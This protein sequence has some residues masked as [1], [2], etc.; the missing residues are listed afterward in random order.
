MTKTAS[1][2]RKRAEREALKA[3][4]SN[5][6][7][8]NSHNA[9]SADGSNTSDPN[10]ASDGG[11]AATKNGP[12]LPKM[13][14]EK[15]LFVENST[16]KD[17]VREAKLYDLL[18]SEN[19]SDR[20]EAAAAIISSLLDGEGVPEAV[21]QRHLDWRLFRGLAS[22]RAASRLG[23]SVVLTEILSQL[24]G[25]PKN[26]SRD[27]YPGLTFENVLGML[28]ERTHVG[29]N[30]PGQ[31]ER[32]L[33]FGQLFGLE[34]FVRARI[35]FIP[36][37]GPERWNEVLRLL[38]KLGN[39]KVW[40]RPQCGWVVAQALAQLDRNRVEMVLQQLVELGWAKTPEGVGIWLVAFE[41]CPDL[42]SGDHAKHH[43]PLASRN[44]GEL[45]G[46]LKES[47]QDDVEKQQQQQ[48]QQHQRRGGFSK[49]KQANWTP[50]LHFVWDLIVRHFLRRGPE[51]VDEFRA[52]WKR[53][54]DD[55][56]FAK[57]ATE[58]QKFRG[59]LV[60]Q[61]MLQ[62]YADIDDLLDV[63]FSRNL[64]T[65]LI[66]QAAQE[67]RFL[68]RAALKTCK[69][70]EETS[71]AHPEATGIILDN[72]INNNGLY[73]FDVMTKS[74]TVDKI[75]QHVKA[76]TGEDIIQ[77]L[78]GPVMKTSTTSK[79][80]NVVKLDLRVYIEYIFR[81]ATS[82]PETA[83]LELTSLAYAKPIWIPENAN[84][85]VTEL[86]RSRLQSAFAK[87][88]RKAE[89]SNYLC[90][91]VLSINPEYI[92]M[93]GEMKKEVNSA[94]KRLE[95]L[96]KK[97]ASA[98]E[99]ASDEVK[100]AQGL[101]LL[102]SIAIFQ[103]YNEEP[104][105]FQLLSDL[106]EY[107]TRL[108]TDEEGAAEFLVEILLALVSQQSSLLREV[109][110]R[111]FGNF[112]ARV[113]PKALELLLDVLAADESAKGQQSL[114]DDVNADDMDVEDL[115][116]DGE[117]D[118]D[119]E[120]G[121][122]IEV[123]SDVEFVALDAGDGEDEEDE[124][125][126]EE[127]GSN[128]D[129]EEADPEAG[130][131]LE[132]LDDA[133]SKIL[134]SHRLDKDQE[135]ESSDDDSD[136]S[137]SDM[138]ELD[139]KLAEVFKQRAK[140]APSKKKERKAAKE[141]VVNFKRRVLDLLEIYVR[142]EAANPTALAI[143]QPLLEL[144]RTSTI[145]TL[146]DRAFELIKD[147]QKR[148]RKARSGAVGRESKADEALALAVLRAVYEELK[149]GETK[150]HAKAAVPACLI[151]ASSV[152]HAGKGDRSAVDAVVGNIEAGSAVQEEMKK[153]WDEWCRNH[154]ALKKKAAAGDS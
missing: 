78:S 121:S 144:V 63:L 7:S 84:S 56:F 142:N 15:K 96:L 39:K 40:L 70:I 127:S 44:L 152:F 66:N 130:K 48:Q 154:E 75:L 29:G 46:I 145:K 83:L 65:C 59:F 72:L 99:N 26:L 125:E 104:D 58:G 33:W 111:V 9:T 37:E 137:D 54:V 134:N 64:M 87:L 80:I 12:R 120:L 138:L 20:L 98:G 151:A 67:D 133:L 107:Q 148:L 45:A 36:E 61:K 57:T 115:E 73:R 8:K 136:M 119:D 85:L 3:A 14:L 95:K 113:S 27:K 47:G 10:D 1:A 126:N 60:F 141:S 18:S 147:Y 25:P 77:V 50:Q 35:L 71:A 88:S 34:C 131:N 38:V 74:K 41:Q 139:N 116:E 69:V 100:I 19:E 55:N 89:D 146:S 16:G 132:A 76:E 103:L 28:M 32:D 30:M 123:D 93:E 24:L 82:A 101:A 52:F 4:D 21:L 105:A 62:S 53:V 124:D 81:L 13:L 129:D 117:D 5:K 135:A 114:F 128:D 11:N 2:K 17:R 49:N 97:S 23:Y 102:H 91:A 6:R 149:A 110:Q 112:T 68:H 79:D 106:K 90:T 94:R 118:S 122:D 109:S 43:H 86:S 92:R 153:A 108:Q 22:G 51:H 140:A 150:A 143:L 42:S 31:E